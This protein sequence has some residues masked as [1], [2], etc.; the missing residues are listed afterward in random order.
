ML[1]EQLGRMEQTIGFRIKVVER[2]GTRLKDMFSLTNLWGGSQC[3]REDCTTCTQ[4]GEDIPDCMRRGIVYESICTKCNPES[5]K[6]GPLK[7]VNKD[8]PSVY[9]GETSRSVYERA[10]EHWKA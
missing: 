7:S 9:V 10:E 3:A 6:P 2:A 1:R 4:E 5:I 8:V